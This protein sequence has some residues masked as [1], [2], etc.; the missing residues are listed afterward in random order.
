VCKSHLLKNVGA[1]ICTPGQSR[2]VGTTRFAF[3]RHYEQPGVRF[4]SHTDGATA[5]I[6][7]K[8]YHSSKKWT[9]GGLMDEYCVS[10]HDRCGA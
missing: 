10:Y 6:V 7:R 5:Y 8:D 1:V 3:Y 2:H 9:S 4:E